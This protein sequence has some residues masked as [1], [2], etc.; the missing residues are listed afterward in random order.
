[1]TK[2]LNGYKAAV[3]T[4]SDRSYAGVREDLGGPLLRELLEDLGFEVVA[5]GLVPDEVDRIKDALIEITDRENIAL[6]VT[7]GGTGFSK[8]DVTPEATIEVCDR[9]A[10][11]IPEMMRAY[12]AKITNRACLSRAQA[13]LRKSS[14][15]INFPGSPKAIKENLEAISD[16]LTHG[17]D[18]LTGGPADC[19]NETNK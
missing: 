8:R 11:G 19:A 1:M 3:L 15:I 12:S 17:L 16:S 10:P 18:M 2:N 9:L 7:T 6:V 4:V 13:G 14:L 5:K